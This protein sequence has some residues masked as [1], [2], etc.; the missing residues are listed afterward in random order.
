MSDLLK[1]ESL[2][3]ETLAEMANEAAAACEASGRK[4]VE[5]AIR[6]GR[7]LLAAKAQ[8]KHGEWLDWVALNFEQSQPMAARYMDIAN[9]SRANNLEQ[10]TSIRDALR[11]IA[12]S[13]EKQAKKAEREARKAEAPPKPLAPATSA[14]P[15][16][17]GTIRNESPP[18][19]QPQP[20]RPAWLANP[21]EMGLPLADD[22]PPQPKTN[23]HYTPENRRQPDA[24]ETDRIG[25]VSPEDPRTLQD[26]R[27]Y[28][29][30]ESANRLFLAT[31]EEVWKA[32]MDLP[33]DALVAGSGAP[34]PDPRATKKVVERERDTKRFVRPTVAEVAAYAA[35]IGAAIDPEQF[36][37]FYTS[38]DWMIGK[39]KM[40]DWK[41]AVRTWKRQQAGKAGT[42]ENGKVRSANWED[43]GT[44]WEDL[45]DG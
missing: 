37:D 22:L 19:Q 4:T 6:C 8:V 3:V 39:N 33:T 27:L 7:A 31:P 16:T 11:L 9:Y 15:V 34:A 42:V 17:V 10:A 36:C 12:D 26:G 25:L 41:A 44:G 23:V 18:T 2:P 21:D 32:A 5:H 14:P 40:K 45:R 24:R 43:D 30:N 35:E 20:E 29:W 38:K 13:P 28:I 1:L